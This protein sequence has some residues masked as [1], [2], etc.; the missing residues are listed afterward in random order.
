MP[1]QHGAEYAVAVGQ[2]AVGG[3]DAVSHG[4]VDEN[5]GCAPAGWAWD[6]TLRK[7]RLPLVPP[8]PK[9]FEIAIS[10][11]MRRAVLG[12]KSRSHWGSCLTRLIVGGATW[13]RSASAVNTASMPPAA[14]SRWPVMDLVELIA[15]FFA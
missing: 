11:F 15:S 7:T 6:Q 13:S 10:I 14:P 8:N 12:T 4:A 9:E 5:H 3:G 1:R 2:P